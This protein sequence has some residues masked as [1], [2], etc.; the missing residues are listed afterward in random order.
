MV[1]DLDGSASTVADYLNGLE[2][3]NKLRQTG[4]GQACD[5][6][7]SQST[8]PIRLFDAGGE[9]THFSVLPASC[10]GWGQACDFCDSQSTLP[11]RLFDAGGE[12]THFSVLPAS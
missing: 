6:C 10:E 1:R 5:F 4:W 3:D 7:D 2:I 12:F 9:F 11:I 8:L